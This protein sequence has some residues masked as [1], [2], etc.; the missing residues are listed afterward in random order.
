MQTPVRFSV[1]EVMN[2]AMVSCSIAC[3]QYQS[4]IHE[5]QYLLMLHSVLPLPHTALVLTAEG[6]TSLICLLENT[7]AIYLYDILAG[8]LTVHVF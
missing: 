3:C 7:A 2:T 6:F 5:E 1:L 4:V 8:Y